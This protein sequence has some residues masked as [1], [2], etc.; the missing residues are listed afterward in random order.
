MKAEN[1]N[2][3]FH[4]L[5]ND[6]VSMT[7]ILNLH[8]IYKDSVSN[9]DLLN[10]IFERQTVIATA[11][12][13]LYQEGD[14]PNVG[15]IIFLNEL[16]SHEGRTLNKYC[17]GVLIK[18]EIADVRLPVKKITPLGQILIE[19]ITNSYRHAFTEISSE[20]VIEFHITESNGGLRF[21]YSDNGLGFSEDF[22]PFKA[23]SLGMQFIVTLSKQ[24]GATP[25]FNTAD[26]STGMS[27]LLEIGL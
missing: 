21:E 4:D 7:S 20:H 5:K 10:R 13:R 15:L 22:D 9:E 25:E 2:S 12:D 17:S 14:Y 19:L 3:I 27:F 26:Q 11:Y 18:K 6:L 24:L 23:R 8:K 1:L 16:I